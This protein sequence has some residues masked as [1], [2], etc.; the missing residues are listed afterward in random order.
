MHLVLRA[1]TGATWALWAPAD[2]LL[3]G[4]P[5]YLTHLRSHRVARPRGC[6]TRPPEATAVREQ[7]CPGPEVGFK[8]DK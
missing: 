3:P 1:D 2:L 4:V 5:L 7:T 6:G 8:R